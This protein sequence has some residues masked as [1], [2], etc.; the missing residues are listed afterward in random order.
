MNNAY[1]NKR[2][3]S[4]ILLGILFLILFTP[5]VDSQSSGDQTVPSLSVP[6]NVDEFPI[7][8][9]GVRYKHYQLDDAHTTTAET[10]KQVQ[11]TIMVYENS[12]PSAVRHVAMYVNHFGPMIMGYPTETS[13]IYDGQPELEIIDPNGIISSAD[14]ATSQLGNKAA[15]TF[16]IV[17]GKEIP[18]SDIIF[19]LWDIRR[20]TMSV[21]IPNALM[22]VSSQQVVE[23]EITEEEPEVAESLTEEVKPSETKYIKLNADEFILPSTRGMT[24]EVMINGYVE[25][26]LRGSAVYLILENPDGER[27]EIQKLIASGGDYTTRTY[28]QH[29]SQVGEYKITIYYNRVI[30]DTISFVA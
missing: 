15:F 18:Q 6:F 16:A 27:I 28:L 14:I 9:D 20:N 25:D 30:V 10:G 17:F 21:Y 23:G 12:G 26:Y 13:L 22:V 11:F 19:R 7:I 3:F 29:D 8:L 2:V 1:R 5:V 4:S 24:T